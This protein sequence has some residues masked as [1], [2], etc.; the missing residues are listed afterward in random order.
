M[1]TMPLR[2]LAATL[3]FLSPV[4]SI[5]AA[6]PP[7]S[8][9]P[10]TVSKPQL[11]ATMMG[12]PLQFEAN[13]GQVDAQVQFLTRGNGYTLF[14]TQTE[15]VMVLQQRE[16]PATTDLLA[17]IDPTAVP[18]AAR[19]KQSVVRMK[20]EGA[21]P[22]P[23]IDGMEP[24][25]G[26][27]NYFIGNDPEKWRTKIPTYAK[28]Q[29]QQAY[30]GIDL[31]YY[32]NQ[33]KLE[34]DFIVAPGADPNQIKLAFEGP[35][36]IRVAESGDLLLTTALG[37]VRMQKPVVYQLETDGRKTLVAGQY[38][39]EAH[40]M[41]LPAA[42][43]ARYSVGFQL[44]SYDHAKLVVIDPVL[45][46]STG[47]GGSST[48]Y[49]N[50]I[51]VGSFGQAYVTGQTSSLDFPTVAPL[52]ATKAGF[53]DAF[54]T[55]LNTIGTSVVY[56]TYL[57]G[58][59]FHSTG[60]GNLGSSIAVDAAGQAYVT[61]RTESPNFPTVAPFQ[62]TFGGGSGDTD[63]F[64]AKLSAAGTSLLYSTYLGGDGSEFGLGIAVDGSGQAYVTGFTSSPNFPTVA[65]LQ[66]TLGGDRDAGDLDAFV[67]KLSATGASALYSTYLGGSNRD[68]GYGIA[69]DA[70]GQAYVTGTTSSPNF[71]TVAPLQ[72]T[73]GGESDAFV[74]KLNATGASLLY[75]TYL[76]GSGFD[77]AS[78]I[79]V[80]ASGQSYVTGTTSSPNFPT[81]APLQATLGGESDAFVTKLS[82]AGASVVYS[83]YLGGSNRD[84]GN[85]IA[86]GAAGLAYVTGTTLSPNF[87]MVTPLQTFPIPILQA[88]FITHISD[89]EPFATLAVNAEIELSHRANH[90]KFEVK[91]TMTLSPSSNGIAPLT[92]AVTVQVGTFSA[93]IPAGSFKLKKGR[94]RFEGVIDGIKL[95]AVLRSMILGNDYEFTVEGKGADFTGTKNPVTVGLTIGDDSGS[96]TI[97]AKIK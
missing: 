84:E 11:T 20:L 74:T 67:T 75:S 18:E 23:A 92:E 30:P 34:Y 94:F 27:V 22:S 16:A 28:V 95:E 21:N 33:G 10:E 48:E 76:G 38:V 32:G 87:P 41:P 68:E 78:G 56:S 65:P 7:T 81:V 59:T 62:S 24:L 61:G 89:Q 9:A 25:P 8:P 35:S 54:V 50:G 6:V 96:K 55:K 12:M 46:Y 2:L 29:Y 1:R 19:M 36:D 51:A 45:F 14:L 77:S 64:V 71:P 49:G 63:A 97:K 58:S 80:D 93:T 66:A 88:A 90:D 37:D 57:G 73:L 53:T 26:I 85:D 52:Q 43:T 79:A 72:A 42:H 82:A 40:S 15:S 91:A 4:L 44:A 86:V 60:Y 17:M 13:H 47:L 39:L 5:E 31:A 70:T 3:L 83:T 69:V